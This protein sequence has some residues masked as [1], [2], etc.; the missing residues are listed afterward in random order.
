MKA[1]LARFRPAL[2]LALVAMAISTV[3]RCVLATRPDVVLA[4]G[5]ADWARVFGYGLLMDAV[6]AAYI[7]SPLVLWLALAP[8]LVARSVVGRALVFGAVMAM[9]YGCLVLA[10]SEWFFWDEF[11]ARFNFIAVDYLL[12]THEVLG[13]IWESYPVGKLLAALVLPVLLLGFLLRRL[14]WRRD[15]ADAA[16]IPR[17]AVLGA[18]ALLVGLSFRYV[19]SDLHKF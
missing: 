12:Y 10:L 3:T 2:V 8:K 17:M 9:T 1:A 11:S 5:A 7:V 16:W 13:N 14:L 15:G 18:Y 6:S 19:D 4:G